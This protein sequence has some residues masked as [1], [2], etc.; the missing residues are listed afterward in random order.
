MRTLLIAGAATLAVLA[1]PPAS[2]AQD[3][4]TS[5]SQD[6]NAPAPRSAKEA[7]LQAAPQ[8][9]TTTREPGARPSEPDRIVTTYP[10]NLRS[11]PASSFDKEY[12]VCGGTVQD[13]CRNRGEGEATGRSRAR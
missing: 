4:S 1:L 12:P 2:I 9:P 10:G 5:Q 6:E 11:P 13:N 8:P 3:A 7:N